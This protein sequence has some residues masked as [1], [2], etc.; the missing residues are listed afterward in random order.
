M[1]VVIAIF[2]ITTATTIPLLTLW[3]E[4]QTISSLS[5]ELL[6]TA[7]RAQG[8]SL[9]GMLGE[10]WGIYV[11]ASGDEYVMFPGV[12]FD[13]QNPPV[14]GSVPLSESHQMSA[15][16]KVCTDAP[17]G[18]IVFPSGLDGSNE[19]VFLRIYDPGAEGDDR[20]VLVDTAGAIEITEDHPTGQTCQ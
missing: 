13:P 11:D 1:L 18:M 3:S 8:R 14:S 16:Y 6:Q 17:N 10:R 7:R 9:S 5:I 4:A 2:V 15:P 12:T 20:Y 19:S